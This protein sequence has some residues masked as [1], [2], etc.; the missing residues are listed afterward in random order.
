MSIR[1]GALTLVV[2]AVLMPARAEA[3]ALLSSTDPAADEVVET[4]PSSVTV[5][6]SE[7]V[8]LAF[9]AL[10]VHDT[11]AKRVDSGE[12]THPE[13]QADAVT[14]ALQPGLPDGTYTVTYRVISSDS[15]PIDGAFVFH[16]G[17][18]GERPEGIGEVLLSGEGGSGTLEQYLGG[19]NRWLLFASILVLAGG[20]LFLVLAWARSDRGPATSV[21]DTAFTK[22][23]RMLMVG[24]W[25]ATVFA[26]ILGFVLQGAVAADVGLVG[27]LSP[28]IGGDLLDTRFGAVTIIRMAVL[29]LLGV[30]WMVATRARADR[31]VW[32]LHRGS[33]VGAAEVTRSVIAM[34][35]WAT[36]GSIALLIV[37]AATPGLS[38]HAGSTS[39]V[40]LNVS[41]DALHVL[42]ASLWMGG[43]VTLVV[44]AFR[45]CQSVSTEDRVATLGPVVA[46]FSDL[47]LIGVGV[48]VLTG[49]YR[50][51]VEVQAWRAFVDAPYG[52]V[53]LTKIG[54]FVPIVFMGAINSRVLK[55]RIAKA[56]ASDTGDDKPLLSLR[57]VVRAEI[58]LGAIVVALTALLVNLPPAKTEAGVSGPFVTEVALGEDSLDVIIDPNEVGENIVHL[59]A[60]SPDGSPAPIQGMKVR[61]RMPAEGIGPIEA[62]GRELAPGHFVVQGH[63][64]TAPGDWVISVEARIDKFTNANAEFEVN[65][66]G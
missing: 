29:A 56:I 45:A 30:G 66:N 60:T 22:R 3:H 55:P 21:V 63:Q 28:E 57:R 17:A 42:A 10:R 50:T 52:L 12:A 41:A 27:A 62:T 15:H 44:V 37:L 11:E 24:A 36:V 34:P 54:I 39:P 20:F 35:R 59:T 26:T 19:I 46:R 65:V 5:T 13:G 31:A 16:V 1:L 43:L 61:F 18:P 53:L 9:G 32:P 48:L 7:P 64:L 38:G 23:W 4:A 58:A 51:W 49:A 8:E 6:F 40:W 47:A 33:T 14:V 25:A 2:A